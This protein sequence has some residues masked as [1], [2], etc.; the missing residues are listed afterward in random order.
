MRGAAAGL[1]AALTF[2]SKPALAPQQL[3]RVVDATLPF[4]WVTADCVYGAAPTLRQWLEAQRL[5]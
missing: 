2:H 4:A 1:P 3:Q 5:A